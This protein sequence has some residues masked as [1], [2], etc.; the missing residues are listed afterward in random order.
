MR[1]PSCAWLQPASEKTVPKAQP[2]EERE[3]RIEPDLIRV[4]SILRAAQDWTRF[5]GRS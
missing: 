1:S 4:L 2:D 3:N 5:F